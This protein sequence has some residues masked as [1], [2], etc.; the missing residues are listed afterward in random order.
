MSKYQA[1]SIK[2][3]Q[4][5]NITPTEIKSEYLS[6]WPPPNGSGPWLLFENIS[7]VYLISPLSHLLSVKSKWNPE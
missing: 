6:N 5:A 1:K 7:Q 3:R 2:K 4:S